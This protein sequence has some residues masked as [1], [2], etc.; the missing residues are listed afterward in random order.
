M[1]TPPLVG[2]GRELNELA[3]ALSQGAASGTVRVIVGEPGIGKTALLGAARQLAGEAGFR[4]L[5]MV[6]VEAE[7]QLPFAGLHQVLSPVL[8]AAQELPAVQ[9]E[10]L[11][12]AFGLFDGP[13]PELSQIAQAALTLLTLVAADQP[14]AVLADDVQ[15][16]DPQTHD[17]LTFLAHRSAGAPVVVIG[18]ARSGYQGPLTGAGFAQ[19]DVRGLD[20]LAARQILLMHG[21]ELS[22]ADLAQL[23]RE[24]LGNPLA[25][26][27]LS[28]AGGPKS[29]GERQPRTL[30]VRL[31]RAFAGRLAELPGSTRDALLVAAVD[32]DDELLEILDATSVMTGSPA[33]SGLLEPAFS[34]GL[35]TAAGEHLVFRHPLVRSGILQAESVGR[36]QA[37][38]R[39]L[40]D[41]LTEQLYR[42]TWHRALSIVGPDDEVADELEHTVPDSLRRGAVSAAV[43]S[44]ERS[45][46]LTSESA[47]RGHRLL[48]AAEH[49]FGLGR[50]DTVSR[51]VQLASRTDLSELDW[52]R[53]QWL[54][55]IFNDGVPGDAHR[56]IELC[57]NARCS[58]DSGDFDLAL[59]L[60]LGAALRCWWADTGPAARNRVAMVIDSLAE[61]EDDARYVA[62]LAVAEPVLSSHEVTRRLGRVEIDEVEDADALRLYGMAAH[63][64]GDTVRATDFLDRSEQSLRAT[65]RLGLLPPRSLGSSDCAGDGAEG[66]VD[67]RTFD[68]MAGELKA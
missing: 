59:N 11:L 66:C 44:L 35:I 20:D 51:L 54:R 43:S 40:A 63:A 30:S 67:G 65:H 19:L 45:A 27:E 23:Q 48:V 50:G 7:A 15:W 9:R 41:V 60:L 29:D 57:A 55:E 6:G 16:L 18:A 21:R 33:T 34:A 31:E 14:V 39:A 5:S 25:L 22:S 12:C 10:A 24:A 52:A 28:A 26:M 47:R 49:A 46:Q 61:V 68:Q 3:A 8:E 42:R 4:V 32:D 1:T 2:R 64:I 62:A 38:H 58:A 17:I 36:R 13:P 56:V 37:A 53:M